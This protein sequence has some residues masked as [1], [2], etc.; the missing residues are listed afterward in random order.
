[1]TVLD[2]E[3]KISPSRSMHLVWP[4]GLECLH[5]RI[6]K[7]KAPMTRLAATA[8]AVSTRDEWLDA[9]RSFWRS[10][11]VMAFCRLVGGQVYIFESSE[12][13]FEGGMQVLASREV[14]RAWFE[15]VPK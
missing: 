4:G 1:M 13:G 9:S 8:G 2:V 5:E 6:A 12:E 7:K 3:R 10:L 15:I 14:K 11:D